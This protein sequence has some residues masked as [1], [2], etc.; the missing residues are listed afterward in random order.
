V[1]EGGDG[2]DER[3]GRRRGVEGFEH[4]EGGGGGLGP[5]EGGGVAG[6]GRGVFRRVGQGM[7]YGGVESAGDSWE[8][9]LDDGGE[10]LFGESGA[11]G[12]WGKGDDESAGG[13]IGRGRPA[14]CDGEQDGA[15]EEELEGFG[16]SSFAMGDAGATGEAAE[17]V[18]DG[19]GEGRDVVE[20]EDPI[21]ASE[22]E[23]FAGG[24]RKRREG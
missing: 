10:L 16:L 14:I 12:E 13:K 18:G 4:I 8:G 17:C 9:L 6:V 24:R 7:T 23:E 22:G 20:G 3:V 5:G 1:E 2:I 15:F 11:I 21:E 19:I